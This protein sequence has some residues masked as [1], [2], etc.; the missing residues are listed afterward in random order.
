MTL[1]KKE[2]RKE[3]APLIRL[4]VNNPWDEKAVTIEEAIETVQKL[5]TRE[6]IA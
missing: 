4:L 5:I 2:I 3:Y 1:S 6:P